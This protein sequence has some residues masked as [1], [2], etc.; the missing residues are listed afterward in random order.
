MAQDLVTKIREAASAQQ[1]DPDVAV[2]IAELESSLNPKAKA[3]T[4]SAKGL[5]QVIDDTWKRY[6]G[7][8]NK[9]LDPEE[10]IQVGVRILADNAARARRA[11]NRD[12][13]PSEL[14]AMHFF[15]PDAGLKVI[16]APEDRPLSAL[17][18]PRV[19]RANPQLRGK[20]AGEVLAHLNAKFPAAAPAMIAA[21]PATPAN[22]AASPIVEEA[23]TPPVTRVS[24]SVPRP[25]PAAKPLVQSA[26]LPAS[27]QAALAVSLLASDDEKERT[28]ENEP[29]IAEQYFAQPSRASPLAS[30]DLSYESP[31]PAPVQPIRMAGGGAAFSDLK[32][33]DQLR[34]DNPNLKVNYKPLNFEKLLAAKAVRVTNQ[35]LEDERFNE[36]P[37]AGFSLVS[38]YNDAIGKGGGTAKWPDNPR[39][40]GVVKD[41]FTSRPQDIGAHKY[42]Q[43][44]ESAKDMGLSDEDIYLAESPVRM[45]TGGDP[46]A[47][48]LLQQ[49]KAPPGYQRAVARAADRETVAPIPGIQYPAEFIGGFMGA[50]P[51]P[52]TNPSETYRIG[53]A[54]GV[55]LMPAA[56]L[57]AK[58][59]GVLPEVLT[60]VGAIGAGVIKPKGGNWPARHIQMQL[61]KIRP[62]RFRYQDPELR[63]ADVAEELDGLR[64][65]GL[66]EQRVAEY[67]KN[68]EPKVEMDKWIT[69]KLGR[70]IQ[71]EMGTESD[72]LLK[73]AKE[74]GILPP[75]STAYLDENALESAFRPVA[76]LNRLGS[77]MRG[78]GAKKTQLERGSPAE[79]WE[80]LV[81]YSIHVGDK[82]TL[83]HQT[84]SSTFKPFRY[85][86]FEA[87]VNKIPP[88]VPIY[89]LDNNIDRTLGFGNLV[90]RLEQLIDSQTVMPEGL[91]MTPKDLE[92]TTVEQAV[93]KVEAYDNWLQEQELKKAM[94]IAKGVP[95]Y[96]P[97]D[98]GSRWL[99][100]DDL[101]NNQN[102]REF[103]KMVGC[104]A[105]W[106]TKADDFID[107]YTDPKGGFKGELHVL[108]SG[109]G[110]PL[111]QILSTYPEK[112][113]VYHHGSKPIIEQ[114]MFRHDNPVI[115]TK[116]KG[117]KKGNEYEVLS[118]V[119]DYIR[120]GDWEVSDTILEQA[121]LARTDSRSPENIK[122]LD[123]VRRFGWNEEEFGPW[124]RFVDE[125][126]FNEAVAR[127]KMATEESRFKLPPMPPPPEGFKEGGIADIFDPADV[128]DVPNV[129]RET[130]QDIRAREF[131][132]NSVNELQDLL[133]RMGK[134][135]EQAKQEPMPPDVKRSRSA[136]QLAAYMR[137]MNPK[138][139]TQD[140]PLE[141][142]L[143]GYV[144]GD[145]PDI[146][147]INQALPPG[148]RE[149]TLLHELEHSMSFRGG[150][151]LGRP[152]PNF[153]RPMIQDNN[154]RAYYLLGEDWKP[155][156]AFIQSMV[157][158]KDKLEK[159]FGEP[160]F[161]AEF[162][163]E[164]L[165]KLLRRDG[166]Y[167]GL[168]EEQLATLSA[169]EQSTGKFLTQDKEMRKLFP[170][171]RMMAVFDALTGPR[172][173]RLD[174]KDLPPH[175]PM[176]PMAYESGAISRFIA[177]KMS[178]PKPLLRQLP[179]ANLRV[180]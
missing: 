152:Q 58:I 1:V 170:D 148:Q 136:G 48:Q 169:M 175:T 126:S 62:N 109:D 87:M 35:G 137:A 40:Y 6:G 120:S 167:Q 141:S 5:F 117:A 135:P 76:K 98:D 23:T 177:E 144:R 73:L 71:N 180:K 127:M 139:E 119:R 37:S 13:R 79:A 146:I 33:Y 53:Q 14:Y 174:A 123:K 89:A 110:K 113:L 108:M 129:P 118:R 52:P 140:M 21:A 179:A 176:D 28:E 107:R 92:K 156:E 68:L 84:L 29:S 178:K 168:F 61:D 147:T 164:S 3:K 161:G 124:Q 70:Y 2:R 157:K 77:E 81:D 165:K 101:R 111:V 24:R 134:S 172:Q 173:T 36:D 133:N 143:W 80:T 54:L 9:Q 163:E 7:T 145:V 105:G 99:R 19:L 150:D 100:A 18:A 26:E 57:P 116:A 85:S 8:P 130:S 72:P 34:S 39:F 43:I 106:C 41:L 151:I 78:F 93:R 47:A 132:V 103:I 64:E 104:N 45:Q 155:I 95:L 75:I 55:G 114:M 44:I 121:K 125:E 63:A 166:N 31:F 67:A 90:T 102:N 22:I 128:N 56:T 91:R 11:L 112:Q 86:E 159:F 83:K 158:N 42:L 82:D 38:G 30:L 16:N 10:N 131:G 59:A 27:Y 162:K 50:E 51:R 17:V 88:N 115:P 96:K 65:A 20:T 60:G 160:V 122:F 74:E 97:Y 69:N 46:R 4:S 154:Y 171:T 32:K 12:P 49:F 138:V 142:T 25:L 66:S 149:R 153:K 15:G 94:A